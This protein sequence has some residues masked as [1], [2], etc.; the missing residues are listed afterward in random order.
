VSPPPA[1]DELLVLSISR[2]EAAKNLPL[3]VEAFAHARSIVPHDVFARMKLVLAGHRDERLPQCRALVDV[4]RERSAERGVTAQV[5]YMFSPSDDDLQ[6]VLRRCVCVVYTP[7]AEHFGYV[8]LEA[9]ASGRPVIAAD[10]GGPTE[11]V[12]EAVTGWLRPPTPEA[13]GTVLATTV[14]HRSWREAAGRA[15]RAHVREH[16]ALDVFGHRLER[17][18]A[19]LLAR[20]Y[21]GPQERRMID[22]A[23][24][25]FR[26]SESHGST[27]QAS[28]A[29]SGPG[30]HPE[31]HEFWRGWWRLRDDAI[32]R[33]SG[34]TWAIL[35]YL[36][37]WHIVR[38]E[39]VAFGGLFQVVT[40]RKAARSAPQG[41][42]TSCG[43][44]LGFL[45]GRL[46]VTADDVTMTWALV[47]EVGCSSRLLHRRMRGRWRWR[48]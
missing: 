22:Q 5:E 39:P 19:R 45:R 43:Y 1:S 38:D 24:T 15:G 25:H 20:P 46:Q 37:Y 26:I 47:S 29:G 30:A 4:L 41:D 13:F 27:R 12:Q 36:K 23:A 10:C 14:M 32:G 40:L 8:P 44:S 3:A 7:V 6:T 16:F 9:M 28:C 11:T 31:Y 42:A 33:T 34:A 35:I 18:I 21:G 2:F 48:P 17:I